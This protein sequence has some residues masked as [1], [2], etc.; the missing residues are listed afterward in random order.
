[1]ESQ[2]RTHT[3]ISG[4][5]TIKNNINV[6]FIKVKAHSNIEM[7]EKVDKLAKDAKI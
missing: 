3:K 4:V 6:E 7:N 1:M 5:D 2:K